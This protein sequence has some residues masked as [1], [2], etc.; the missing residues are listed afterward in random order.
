MK[1]R[2]RKFSINTENTEP[3][4]KEIKTNVKIQKNIKKTD[5]KTRKES[6]I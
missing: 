5:K 3:I 1:S 4:I 6:K 2:I